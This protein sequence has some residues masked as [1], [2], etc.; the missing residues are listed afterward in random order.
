MVSVSPDTAAGSSVLIHQLSRH[1]TQ[2]PFRRASKGSAVQRAVFHPSKPVLF[3]ATQRYV[4]VYDLAAQSLSRTLAPGFRWISSLAIHASGDHVL[5]G[6]YDRKIAWFDLDLATRPFKILRYHAK[7]VRAVAFHPR[8]PLFL[9]A[10]DDA[11]TQVFH[12]TVYNELDRNPLI[13]PLKILRGHQQ[14]NSLGIL[15]AKWHPTQ[16]W[17]VTAAADGQARL[18][19]P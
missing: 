6:S 15:D 7:A 16:P 13:V 3:V 18:W 2:A 1:R 19:T 11:T 4:R 17:L 9:S 8:Y 10:S 14:S 12:G 5:V